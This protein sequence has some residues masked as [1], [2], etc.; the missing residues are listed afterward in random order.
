M[1]IYVVQHGTVNRH[2]GVGRALTSYK[3][4]DLIELD[5]AAALRLTDQVRPI[6]RAAALALVDAEW[7]A[8]PVVAR[9]KLVVQPE[10]KPPRRASRSLQ[11]R[12]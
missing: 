4:G 11:V 10:A 12:L 2:E 1:P 9:R 8:A 5:G 3:R 7:P 6:D